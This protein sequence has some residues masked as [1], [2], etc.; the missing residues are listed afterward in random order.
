[1]DKTCY[2]SQLPEPVESLTNSV[3]VVFHS[4]QAG[5]TGQGYRLEWQEV[6]HQQQE[7]VA[8]GWR[9]KYKNR[10]TILRILVP[11]ILLSCQ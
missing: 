6:D 10:F 2:K 4:D 1:M 3:S 9:M 7:K 11:S 5:V 8:T